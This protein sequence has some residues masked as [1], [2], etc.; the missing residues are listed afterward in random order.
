M[1]TYLEWTCTFQRRQE[2]WFTQFYTQ[3][4]STHYSNL[5]RL[6]WCRRFFPHSPQIWKRKC[7]SHSFQYYYQFLCYKSFKDYFQISRFKVPSEYCFWNSFKDK[8][9]IFLFF[10]QVCLREPPFFSHLETR[11]PNCF[12]IFSFVYS[13][14]NNTMKIRKQ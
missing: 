11:L 13:E 7:N 6:G 2:E 4:E 9:L 5:S 10:C 3:I 1:I 12:L 14:A 8:S